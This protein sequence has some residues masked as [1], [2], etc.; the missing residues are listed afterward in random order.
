MPCSANLKYWLASRTSW[1]ATRTSQFLFINSHVL[2]S[3]SQVLF[4]KT[5]VLFSK[6][7]VLISKTL[8]LISK[9]HA[10]INTNTQPVNACL[11]NS[12]GSRSY[13][14]YALKNCSAK[15]KLRP[16]TRSIKYRKVEVVKSCF[17][18]NWLSW[19]SL[20]H[21]PFTQHM[22]ILKVSRL[23]RWGKLNKIW[24]LMSGYRVLIRL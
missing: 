13:S 11:G 16:L 7:H 23:Q 9:L 21:Q 3:K 4:N 10:L 12:I 2:L 15:R 1:L 19:V 5:Q 8:A 17:F 20:R 6:P 24:F 14:K 22:H 18:L